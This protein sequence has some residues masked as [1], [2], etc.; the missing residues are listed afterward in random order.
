MSQTV[1]WSDILRVA[2]KLGYQVKNSRGA[3]RVFRHETRKPDCVTFHEPH[4]G[5]VIYLTRVAK[6]FQISQRQVLELAQ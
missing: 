6:R 5:Q 2:Q 4:G 1:A 3:L